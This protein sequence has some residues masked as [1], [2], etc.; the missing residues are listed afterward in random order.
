MKVSE[1]YQKVI[2]GNDAVLTNML[3]E[4]I[5][6]KARKDFGGYFFR[7]DNMAEPRHG[8]TAMFILR[9]A[10]A[11]F[12]E[13]SI[14]YGDKEIFNRLIA[15][16]EY[17]KR[18]QRESG[19]IDLPQGNFDS[20]PDTSF[21]IFEIAMGI[22]KAR[23]SETKEA[24]LFENCI[25]PFII[26]GANAVADGGFHT[27]NHRWMIVGALAITQSLYP[28]LDFTE[29]IDA[30]LNEGIDI[31]KDGFYTERSTGVYTGEI[32]TRLMAAAVELN[33]PYLMECVYRSL[34]CLCNFSD[35]DGSVD[36]SVSGRQDSAEY[37]TYPFNALS[38]FIY[39]AVLK[40]DPE[41]AGV[42]LKLL[43][44]NGFDCPF[45]IYMLE[46]NADIMNGRLPEPKKLE[47]IALFLEDSGIY[48]ERNENLSV[49]IK[50]YASNVMKI[51]YGNVYMNEMR[52]YSSYFSGKYVPI[53]ME[54]LENGVRLKM[55][56][57]FVY[58]PLPGYWKPT[59]RKYDVK[60]WEYNRNDELEK[61]KQGQYSN[62][63]GREIVKRPEFIFWLTIMRKEMGFSL[64]IETEGG[65]D[66]VPFMAE[67]LFAA[68]GVAETKDIAFH[69]NAG[70]TAFLKSDYVLYHVGNDY[71]KITGGN[72]SHRNTK[73][74]E[75]E[76][77]M[78]RVVVPDI[79]PVKRR[80][81][82]EFGKL[83]GTEPY[84]ERG[85][86]F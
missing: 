16:C 62:Y 18:C 5:C 78:F 46:R 14:Y 40:N 36:T 83:C 53:E 15:A 60:G 38:G 32:N 77:G 74:S 54:K 85:D 57:E 55:I 2:V 68:G 76:K 82:L 3:G 21:A 12:S 73:Y 37:K 51:R 72:D 50:E 65:M 66:N 34:K 4:Q 64:E 52:L 10:L 42:A 75:G 9:L 13:H 81:E 41:L 43:S 30:Y 1:I 63:A 33:K 6:D 86:E 19:F 70:E 67:F 17:E 44:I 84:C 8:M 61:P 11:Y 28:E 39:C 25:K 29:T 47:N 31:N 7:E 23:N 26:K 80:I 20:P 58:S 35:S 79:T 22:H 27:T 49:V 24:E 71:I 48:R 45:V 69:A 56:S 59:G